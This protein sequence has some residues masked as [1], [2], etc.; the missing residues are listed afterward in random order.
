MGNTKNRGFYA[1]SL[2]AHTITFL[3]SIDIDIDICSVVMSYSFIVN[4]LKKFSTRIE[5]SQ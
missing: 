1:H 4:A 3:F 5:I 2:Q